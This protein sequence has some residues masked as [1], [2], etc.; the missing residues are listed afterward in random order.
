MSEVELEPLVSE[1]LLDPQ[2]RSQCSSYVESWM[3]TKKVYQYL[4][5]AVLSKDFV[6]RFIEFKVLKLHMQVRYPDLVTYDWVI[7]ESLVSNFKKISDGDILSVTNTI[8]VFVRDR[9]HQ[10]GIDLYVKGLKSEA[11]PYLLKA[12][13]FRISVDPFINPLEEGILDKLKAQDMPPGGKVIKSSMGLVNNVLLYGGYKNGDL[14]MVCGRPK[15][16]KTVLMVQEGA[17]ATNQGFNVAHMFFGD[18]TNFDGITKYMSCITGDNMNSVI[19]DYNIYKK[20][21]ER[22]LEHL[23]IASFPAMGVDCYEVIS[24]LEK[25]KRTFDFNMIVLDYD[26]NIRQPT[27]MGMYEAG[28]VLYSV[29]KGMGTNFG[30]PVM[31]GSQPKINFWQDEILPMEAAAESSRKQHAV[32]VMI[33]IGR[34]A[35]Y[36]KIGTVNIPLVRRGASNQFSRV[37]FEDT[38]TRI[39]DISPYE[40]EKLFQENKSR[41]AE[42]SSGDVSLEGQ[43]FEDKHQAA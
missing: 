20:R 37:I 36:P 23:R 4:V 34:N 5:E 16:G 2:V 14:I 39:T 11:E 35:K 43:K 30:C 6:G 8:S 18:Q 15:V 9:L 25:L 3:F 42:A 26:L 32:D 41:A 12:T 22:W 38:R 13:T 27:E 21:C 24:Y 33:T 31:I 40:Y 10:K 7:I 29:T 28:G 19:Q 17:S 1:I